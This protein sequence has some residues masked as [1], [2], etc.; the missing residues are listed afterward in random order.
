M[1]TILFSLGMLV[2][3]IFLLDGLIGLRKIDPLEKEAGMELGPL[4]SVVVAARNE[5]KQIE[6]SILSQLEQTYKNVEWIL[7]NDRSTDMTGTIMEELTKIDPRL[8]VIHVDRLPE[9]WLGKNNALYTGALQASGK[10]LLFTDADVKFEK[11]AFAKAL[12]YFERHKL[13]HLTAAPNLSANR[14]WLKSFVAFF[15]FGFSY[16]KRPW[17]AN[18]PKSKIGTGIGAFILVLKKSYES[19]GTHEKIKMRP[20]DDLQLGMKMKKA[21]YRQRIVTALHLIEVEW[22]GSL[23]EALVG[24][25]KNTFAGLHYRISMVIFAILGVFITNVLPF[26]MIF[27]GNTTVALLS[28]GNIVLCGILYVI[29][30]KKLTLFSPLMFLVFPITALLFI[31][32]IIRA[33]LLTFKRGGIVWRGTTYRLSEL[34]EKD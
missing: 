22:Y 25:E 11:Q 33:S 16:F 3:T 28:F 6:A 10:W 34:R 32:S 20:D 18:N 27:S 21:G 2:W 24:L 13:D 17:L 4:L 31:Y 1:L 8:K 9:G 29:V 30:I 7:V 14:F 26:V 19:F 15:L 23:K 12:H 5:E